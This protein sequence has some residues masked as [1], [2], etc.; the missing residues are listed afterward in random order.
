MIKIEKVASCLDWPSEDGDGTNNLKFPTKKVLSVGE[1]FA[2]FN[3]RR[4]GKLPFFPPH[5]QQQQQQ[6]QIPNENGSSRSSKG[7]LS[8]SSKN[9]GTASDKKKIDF[10]SLT[11]DEFQKLSH[12]DVLNIPM[13]STPDKVR[14]AFHKA[15]LKYHPD[16]TGRGEEDY[17]FL[18]LKEAFDVLSDETSKRSYD[19]VFDFDDS[20][21]DGNESPKEFYDAYGPVFEANLRFA[22][23]QSNDNNN[24]KGKKGN[25]GGKKNNYSEKATAVISLG[26]DNTP[27]EQV[28][29]FYDY[30]IKFESWRDFTL[31]ASKET[32]HDVDTADC[33]EEKRWMQKEIDRKAKLFKK[34]EMARLNLLV[35]RAMACDPRLKREKILREIEKKK[36]ADE[37]KKRE[38]EIAKKKKEK[39][40]QERKEREEKERKEQQQ[41]E[42]KKAQKE[43]EKKALRKAKQV[44]RKYIMF[45][46]QQQ[47]N[48]GKGQNFWTSLENMNDDMELICG[49]SMQEIQELNNEMINFFGNDYNENTNTEF[50]KEAIITLTDTIKTKVSDIKISRMSEKERQQKIRQEK[51]EQ[52][53]LRDS[54]EKEMKLRESMWTKEELSA[55]AK[56]VKKYPAGGANR[57]ETIS[58]FINNLVKPET[59]KTKDECIQQYNQITSNRA[60]SVANKKSSSSSAA[61]S[62]KSNGNSKKNSSLANGSATSGWTAEQD[63]QLEKGLSTFP[64]S[65]DKNERWTNIAKGVNGKTKK[66]CVQR[67][68]Q[69][70]E[71]IKNRGK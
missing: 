6:Q 38:E 12:Y 47:Q 9:K 52:E 35:E 20:I 54:K 17:I 64:S 32:K 53:K 25:K 8:F 44:F 37:R 61:D 31:K 46:F 26:D 40:E 13:H 63:S 69:I 14:K 45:L 50:S 7:N 36:A 24:R 11:E 30:W 70:R 58:N 41:R 22:V 59:P 51:R 60:M 66:E 18:K 29:A 49:Q 39:E 1:S 33:R 34:E 21:P 5:L 10:L 27:I 56:G 71:A 28:H 57:W 43:K 4:Q 65:M 15:C 55:L 68:K 3:L 62:S 19:S 2:K 67:F 42:Q 48:F 16:K 23:H